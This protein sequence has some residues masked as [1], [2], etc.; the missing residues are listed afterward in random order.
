M[1]LLVVI[2]TVAILAALLIPAVQ[3]AR[4][5]ARRTQCA[6]HFKQ[7]ALATLNFASSADD[8]L[9]ALINPLGGRAVGD[10]VS[11]RFSIL[12]FLEKEAVHSL[13]S[14]RTDWMVAQRGQLPTKPIVVADYLCPTTPGSPRLDRR[15]L[16]WEAGDNAPFD[17]F[18]CRDNLANYRLFYAS[19]DTGMRTLSPGAW[20]GIRH[21]HDDSIT[22]SK[23]KRAK[24]T[25]I[26]DGL[27]KTVLVGEQS[28]RPEH[29]SSLPQYAGGE[30][31]AAW[32]VNRN[33]ISIWGEVF[34]LNE[35]NVH[36]F[37]SYHP[38]GLH[39]SMCDGSVQFLDTAQDINV[40]VNMMTRDQTVIR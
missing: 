17:G 22:L 16:T 40:F 13:L 30:V 14:E 11:W 34:R 18:A 1:E 28:G 31:G 27:S 9:P 26:T 39:V 6:N 2:A 7:V 12:P 38:G 15:G 35:S 36:G 33:N 24:L 19:P 20:Y 3:A 25:Y 21:G 29:I 32:I 23:T 37:Y 5:A 8:R 10:H 4:E